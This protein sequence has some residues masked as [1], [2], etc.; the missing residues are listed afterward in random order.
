MHPYIDSKLS[1]GVWDFQ[2]QSQFSLAMAGKSVRIRANNTTVVA[3][4]HQQGGTKW[5]AL[6]NLS[7]QLQAFEEE[8][9]VQ[10][11]WPLTSGVLSHPGRSTQL[12]SDNPKQA[13]LTL[14]GLPRDCRQIGSTREGH[15]PSVPITGKMNSLW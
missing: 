15:G 3:Y 14:P 7:S 2:N 6:L 5:S 12:G 11:F 4:I 9:L 10:I 13:V 8:L 1:Q